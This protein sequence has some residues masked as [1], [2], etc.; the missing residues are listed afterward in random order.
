MASERAEARASS[1]LM[2]VPCGSGLDPEGL[3][4]HRSTAVRWADRFSASPLVIWSST[5]ISSNR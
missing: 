4:P 1:L 2:I 3:G 5:C